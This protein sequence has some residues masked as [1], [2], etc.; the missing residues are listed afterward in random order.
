MNFFG[1]VRKYLVPFS[2][3]FAMFPCFAPMSGAQECFFL[4]PILNGRYFP[5]QN[6]WAGSVISSLTPLA[7]QRSGPQRRRI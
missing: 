6:R 1:V 3:I 5:A 2:L 4:F 7:P